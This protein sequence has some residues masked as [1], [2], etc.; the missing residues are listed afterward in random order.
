MSVAHA[1]AV[2]QLLSYFGDKSQ[3]PDGAWHLLLVKAGSGGVRPCQ[4]RS[5]G[6]TFASPRKLGAPE[7]S[8]REGLTHGERS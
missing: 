7:N 1:V 2:V 3:F 5:G 8:A 6:K 4:C